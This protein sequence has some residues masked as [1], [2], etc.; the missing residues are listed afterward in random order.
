M[1]DLFS[2][3]PVK[4]ELWMHTK[5]GK[6]YRIEGSSFNAITDQVDVVY[7]PCYDCEFDRFTRQMFG[8]EKAF[9][10]LNDDGEP[11]FQRVT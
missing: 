4:G 7:A 3:L 1:S 8:H 10:S 2:R 6:T 5:T 9:L 11:R